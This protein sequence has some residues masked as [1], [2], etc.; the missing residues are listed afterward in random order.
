M[1]DDDDSDSEKDSEVDSDEDS[2]EKYYDYKERLDYLNSFEEADLYELCKM[3]KIP[4]SEDSNSWIKSD[5]IVDIILFESWQYS[6]IDNT[7]VSCNLKSDKIGN[8]SK[9]VFGYKDAKGK[10]GILYK[11]GKDSSK[12]QLYCNFYEK[13]G[14]RENP[15]LNIIN[16]CF[17][18]DPLP[19]M[20]I[21][22]NKNN[23]EKDK[24]K[25]ELYI[26]DIID[27]I[28][29]NRKILENYSEYCNNYNLS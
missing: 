7:K 10:E 28:F 24:E 9:R 17:M 14:F 13:H 29:I 2:D 12:N 1:E 18:E 3:Y 4:V 16:K 23:I 21:N 15:N 25:R 5:L 6:N 26:N 27:T 22:L 20:E 11:M 8:C 19:S